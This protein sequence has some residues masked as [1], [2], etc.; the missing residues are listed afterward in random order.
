MSFPIIL[1]HR[2][3]IGQ[4]G[5]NKV[6]TS[7]LSAIGPALVARGADRIVVPVPGPFEQER[8]MEGYER[9]P[10]E[11][12]KLV[13][14]VDEDGDVLRRIREYLLPLRHQARQWPEDAFVHFVE[15]FLYRCALAAKYRAGVAH[16]S[17]QVVREFIPIINPAVFSDEARYRFADVIAL[18]CAYRPVSPEYPGFARQADVAQVG[19]TVWQIIESAEFNAVVA[20]SPALGYLK[21]PG[22]ALAVLRDKIRDLVARPVAKGL[23]T[24]SKSAADLAGVGKSI[25]SASRIAEFIDDA[26]MA[27]FRPPFFNLGPSVLTLY[28]VALEEAFPGAHA[29]EGTIMV[30]EEWRA[31]GA[32]TSWLSVGEEDKLEREEQ[33]AIEKRTLKWQEAVRAQSLFYR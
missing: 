33:E 32:G 12:R 2:D 18:V 23:I 24:A 29:P 10:K 15:T 26:S 5:S 8:A 19:R 1:E 13:Q 25:E 22:L 31:G 4:L 7:I 28:R 16:D 17:V 14:F 9:L 21:E 3:A 11:R 6:R 20:E 30:F 27:G